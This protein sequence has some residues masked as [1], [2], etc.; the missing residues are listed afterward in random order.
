MLGPQGNED[1]ARPQQICMVMPADA[2]S[3]TAEATAAAG[4][5]ST[6]NFPLLR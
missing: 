2:G 1:S 4:E 3:N 5:R 6:M